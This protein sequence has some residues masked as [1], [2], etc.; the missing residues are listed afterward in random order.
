MPS[1]RH[2]YIPWLLTP[3]DT[4]PLEKEK[5]LVK[6]FLANFTED[7]HYATV[8]LELTFINTEITMAISG[9]DIS[10]QRSWLIRIMSER[11][12]QLVH[13]WFTTVDCLKK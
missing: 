2:A 13:Q 1:C 4:L 9:K 3:S 10:L 7:K 11:L 8:D 6:T 5:K 12:V